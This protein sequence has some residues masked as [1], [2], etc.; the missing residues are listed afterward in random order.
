MSGDSP[1]F[2]HLPASSRALLWVLLAVVVAVGLPVL[3]WV[4]GHLWAWAFT[5]W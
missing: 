1:D 4:V 3:I 2:K 5:A